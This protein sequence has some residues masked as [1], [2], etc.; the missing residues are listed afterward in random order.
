MNAKAK[1]SQ[2]IA[3][4][5]QAT[6]MEILDAKEQRVQKQQKLLQKGSCLLCFTLNIPGSIKCDELFYQ[7]FQE[8]KRLILQQL[9]WHHCTILEQEELHSK[10]GYEWYVLCDES[11]EKIK[12]Q[13]VTIEEE[14]DFGRLLDI[15][16]LGQDGTKISRKDIAMPPRRCLLCDEIATGCSR[17]RKHSYEEL[18]EK[19][20]AI[21]QEYFSHQFMD[22]VAANAIRALIYEVAATPKPGLVD[23]N[24]S[25][26]HK[27][28]DFLTFVDSSAALTAHFRH[29]VEKGMNLSD[30]AP[31]DVLQYLRYPGRLA[32]VDMD[33]FT[34]GINCHKGIIFSMGVICTAIGMRYAQGKVYDSTSVL[35]LSGEICTQLMKDFED[36]KT[37]YS[38]GEKLYIEY[39]VTGIRG[40]ASKG[41]PSIRKVG[42][43]VLKRYVQKGLS[44]NDAG[45][46]TLLELLCVTQDSNILSRSN[47]DTLQDVQ[48]KVKALLAK[49][50]R[51]L[52]DVEQLNQEFV[53][54]NISPGGCAD[55]LALSYFLYFMEQQS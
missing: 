52:S 19:V 2:L 9:D 54:K 25:G 26:S 14:N 11:A 43:P 31:Q 17:S 53:Q 29:F 46:W 34:K 1:L 40:E 33:T 50:I 18:M 20:I 27:D 32:E 48:K 5:K 23:R 15:D 6:L 41:Y 10:A 35:A 55:L 30:T 51:S 21:L 37:P 7:G 38:H 42:L 16:V 36:I 3:E 39:G 22:K 12:K 45:V 4:G 8:G 49:D 13:M 47:M 28:M 24:N 44:L